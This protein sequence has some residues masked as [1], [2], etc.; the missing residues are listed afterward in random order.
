MSAY[1]LPLGEQRYRPTEHTVGPWSDDA[2]H[3]GP[4]TALLARAA[5]LHDARTDLQFSRLTVEI[6]GP[7]P[8]RDLTVRTTTLRD[9]KSVQLL[10]A[11]LNCD[12][13]TIAKLRAWRHLISDTS[14]VADP[15]STP[16]STPEDSPV[17]HW[18]GSFGDSG[19]IDSVEWRAAEDAIG[20][21]GTGICWAR[22]TVPL[23]DGEPMTNLQN[24]LTVVDS[25]S[26]ISS[27]VNGDD[28]WFQNTDLTVHLH[29]QPEGDWVGIQGHAT[30]GATGTAVA[31][32]VTW[33]RTGQ[34]GHT[35]QTLLVRKR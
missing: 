25:T 26:G 4:V 35:A 33:D 23:V 15:L 3:F 5:G 12:G 16:G 22:P 24:L 9:G 21:R 18:P 17:Y 10:G 20:S 30:F 27:P 34:V 8:L 32:G 1:Y 2:Q 31:A 29:R 6:W 13:R 11:E 28:W 19:Y 7:A 14:I